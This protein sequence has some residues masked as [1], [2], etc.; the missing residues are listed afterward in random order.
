MGMTPQQFFESFVEPNYVDFAENPG[1]VRRAFNA[2]VSASHLIDHFYEYHCKYAAEKVALYRDLGEFVERVSSDTDGCFS[3]IRSIANAYKHLYTR[4]NAGGRTN[5]A[6]S[7]AG[8]IE[9][10]EFPEDEVFDTVVSEV[11][12]VSEGSLVERVVFTRRDGTRAEFLPRL[13][14]V[15]EYYCNELWDLHEPV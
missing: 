7:S 13:S 1:C 2:G 11:E 6:V 3:D 15:I 14:R 9:A 12:D 8:A 5:S 10:I 4:N